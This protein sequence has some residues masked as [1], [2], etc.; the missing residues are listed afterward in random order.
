MTLSRGFLIPCQSNKKM[1]GLVMVL[2]LCT[3]FWGALD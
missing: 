3:I 1:A 2:M